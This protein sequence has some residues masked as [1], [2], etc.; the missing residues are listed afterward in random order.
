MV[1]S[2]TSASPDACSNVSRSRSGST[3]TTVGWPPI[4]TATSR[5]EIGCSI[6]SAIPGHCECSPAWWPPAHFGSR[7]RSHHD[8]SLGTARCPRFADRRAHPRPHPRPQCVLPTGPSGRAQRGRVGDP[9]SL[10]RTRRTAN[11]G[12]CRHRRSRRESPVARS[13]CHHRRRDRAPRP[14]RSLAAR[15]LRTPPASRIAPPAQRSCPARALS[16]G[17]TASERQATNDAWSNSRGH[18]LEATHQP[19]VQTVSWSADE[20]A[21]SSE[22]CRLAGR[23]PSRCRPSSGQR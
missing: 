1:T 8:I 10:H 4:P 22:C 7:G 11:S 21:N 9:G 19:C 14:R 3:K 18:S 20:A 5:S 2:I 17:A 13:S 23:G 15:A 6:P 12:T 16:A